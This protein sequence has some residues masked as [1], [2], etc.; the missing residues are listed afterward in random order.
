MVNSTKS[1]QYRK[2]P[3]PAL[4]RLCRIYNLME[5]LEVK[6]D[7]SISSR[8]IGKRLGVGSHNIRKD[9]SY[10]GETGISGSGYEIN[11][12]KTHIEAA[13]GL[14]KERNACI[15]GLGGL[16]I[17]IM[18]YQKPLFPHFKIIAGFDSNIN[19]LETIEISIPVYPTYE[20]TE[21]IT[22]KKI[23][24]AVITEPDRNIEKIM[25]RLYKGGIKGIINFTPMTMSS[26]YE[27]VYIR[28]IDIVTEFRYLSALFSM[29]DQKL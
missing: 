17:V 3:K 4:S 27:S 7:T 10:I 12:L 20:I 18:N 29:Q 1:M 8:E 21:I 6:G 14:S 15:I 22:E 28:N 5:E 26:D 9:I 24:L 2:I 16:G 11:R 19:V 25:E 23:E 13:L